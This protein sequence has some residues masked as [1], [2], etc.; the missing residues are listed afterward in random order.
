MIEHRLD[1]QHSILHIKPTSALKEEDFARLAKAVDPQI[2]KTGGLAGLIVEV[3]A[4]PGWDSLGALAAHF[5]FV[6]DHHKRVRKVA[7]VTD[8]PIGSVAEKLAAHFVAAQIKHFPAGQAGAAQKWILGGEL[9]HI[10]PVFR[11]KD[12]EQSIAYYRDRLG[13]DVEFVYEGFYGSVV[14]D[15]CHI[16]LQRGAWTPRDQAA[17]EKA[18]SLD[19]CIVVADAKRLSRNLSDAGVPFTVALR[20]MPYGTEFYLRDPDGYILGFVQPARPQ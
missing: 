12:L 7:I 5:R 8:A 16:H 6:R 17:F 1:A 13:F 3:S 15:G 14:R 4:F 19:A 20:E 2:E 10:A 9:S 18:E 11:V